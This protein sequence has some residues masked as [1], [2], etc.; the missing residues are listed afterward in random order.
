MCGEEGNL[1]LRMLPVLVLEAPHLLPLHSRVTH[2]PA[3]CPSLVIGPLSL[4]SLR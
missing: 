1:H 3:L 4:Q 2:S